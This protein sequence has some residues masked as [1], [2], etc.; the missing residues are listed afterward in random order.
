MAKHPLTLVVSD[1][2]LGAGPLLPDGSDNFL[3]DFFHDHKFVEFLDYYSSDRFAKREV[4]LVVGGDFFNHLQLYPDEPTPEH[5]TEEVALKRTKAIFDGHAAV[6]AALARFAAAPHHS[7]VFI[8]GNHDMGLI[9]PRVQDYVV[10]TLG[11]TARVHKAAVY[12]RGGVW[13]EHGNQQVAENR[14]DYDAPFAR[15]QGRE[16]TLKLPWGDLFVIKYLNKMKRKRP[17]IDKVYPFGY[18]LKWALIHDTGFALKA[19]FAGLVYFF[20]VMLTG[21]DHRGISR[22]QFLKII[23]EFSFPVRMHKAARRIFALHPEVRIVVF[24]HGHHANSRSFAGGK[25]YFN[26]G[27]WNEMISL[28]P[29]TMGRSLRLTFVEIERDGGGIPTG[30]LLEWKGVHHEVE[31]MEPL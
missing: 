18:Y 29:G 25:Q 27:I 13:I 6:F 14:I 8:I 24:G 1:F 20:Q 12:L 15:E 16:I 9:W 19:S 23:K 28:D 7:I 2:H 26:S 4:E 30:R 21:G 3:E 22:L 11:P 31:E 10:R 5:M 17:Y